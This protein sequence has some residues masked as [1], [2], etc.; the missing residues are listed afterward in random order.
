VLKRGKLIVGSGCFPVFAGWSLQ[1]IWK[2]LSGRLWT[3]DEKDSKQLI[4][5]NQLSETKIVGDPTVN[6]SINARFNFFG[7][8]RHL[9]KNC[10]TGIVKFRIM[11]PGMVVSAK[12]NSGTFTIVYFAG[13]FHLAGRLLH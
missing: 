11:P 4:R 10:S 7:I 2:K 5:F 13:S 12:S 8:Y 9:R 3:L 1:R 6:N